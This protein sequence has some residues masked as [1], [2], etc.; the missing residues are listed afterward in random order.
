[1][2]FEYRGEHAAERAAVS[3]MLSKIG[4]TADTLR[5]WARQAKRDQD[6]RAASR[7]ARAHQGLGA[8]GSRAAAE[9]SQIYVPLR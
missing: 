3:S 9:A 7:R 2:V 4:Y 1:M 5:G 6:I 8:G